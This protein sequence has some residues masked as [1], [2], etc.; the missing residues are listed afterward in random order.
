MDFL[1][2]FV[3]RITDQNKEDKTMKRRWI[4]A[5]AAAL[6]VTACVTGAAAAGRGRNFVDAD[7][8]GMC[9]NYGT[10]RGQYFV[11][12]DGDGVCDNYG[13]GRGAGGCGRGGCRNWS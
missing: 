12:A 6:M 3:F 1:C 4:A 5:A 8:D 13:T 7:G 2:P 11:D 9:D 10:G